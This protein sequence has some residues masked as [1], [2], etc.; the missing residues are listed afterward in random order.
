MD[1][2][3]LTLGGRQTLFNAG[4]K[5]GIGPKDRGDAAL[6]VGVSGVLVVPVWVEQ[7]SLFVEVCVKKRVEK[8]VFFA[9]N[10]FVQECS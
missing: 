10:A 7:C 5:L 6:F 4:I 1:H 8:N 9:L 2:Y 3:C